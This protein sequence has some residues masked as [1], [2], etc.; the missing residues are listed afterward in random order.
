MKSEQ[1]AEKNKVNVVFFDDFDP[2]LFVFGH[3]LFLEFLC[4][5]TNGN[6]S[7]VYGYLPDQ[8]REN[9]LHVRDFNFLDTEQL[10]NI[11]ICIN[12]LKIKT[13]AKLQ[14]SLYNEKLQS[15]I[16]CSL[17]R[18]KGKGNVITCHLQ[19]IYSPIE[20][21]LPTIY[22][23]TWDDSI[24]SFE[25]HSVRISLDDSFEINAVNF[26][27]LRLTV[28]GYTSKDVGRILELSEHTVNDYKKE[29]FKIFKADS[30]MQLIRYAREKKII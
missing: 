13:K 27:I 16:L 10:Q 5:T 11:Q 4:D 21:Y 22:R 19:F 3:G 8:K 29:L 14:F 12:E 1:I 2:R 25:L 20:R 18:E 23:Y 17:V 9:I 7:N 26:K 6:V 24:N 15:N 30:L 28:Q